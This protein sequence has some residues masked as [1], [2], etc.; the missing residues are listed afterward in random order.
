[1]F[2]KCIGSVFLLSELDVD[3]ADHVVSKV[4]THIQALDLAVLSELLKQVFVEFL[5]IPVGHLLYFSFHKQSITE[6]V[7]VSPG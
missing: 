5:N 2:A 7:M 6:D 1:M 4:V 3:I